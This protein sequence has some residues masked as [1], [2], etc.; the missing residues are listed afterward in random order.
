MVC[1]V[2]GLTTIETLQKDLVS[3]MQD[4]MYIGYIGGLQSVPIKNK[5]LNMR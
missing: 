2:L 4:V 1:F 5:F 3:K